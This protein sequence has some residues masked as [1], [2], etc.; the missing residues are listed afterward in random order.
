MRTRKMFLYYLYELRLV[1]FQLGPEVERACEVQSRMESQILH[2][3][4]VS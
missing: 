1:L 3:N 4:P 2:V